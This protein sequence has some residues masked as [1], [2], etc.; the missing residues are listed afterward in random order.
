MQTNV[1]Q[2][3][4]AAAVRA[5]KTAAQ[6]ALGVIGASAAMGDVQW[7]LVGSAAVLAAIVSTLTSVVGV[8]EVDEGASIAKI[9]KQ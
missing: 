6:A 9:A 8:P 4:R 5:A 3:V 1:K 7:A 2:W